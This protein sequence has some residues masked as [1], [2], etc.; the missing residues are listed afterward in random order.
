MSTKTGQYASVY[1]PVISSYARYWGNQRYQELIRK[2]NIVDTQMA[3]NTKI[4]VQ[5]KTKKKKRNGVK[6]IIKRPIPRTLQPRTKLIRVKMTDYQYFNCTTGALATKA[7]SGTD[8][9]NPL[10]ASSTQ[11]P[12]GYDQWKA[13]Y[14]TAYIVGTKVKMTLWNNSTTAV[15]CGITAMPKASASTALNSYEHYKELPHTHARMLSPDVDYGTVNMKVSTKKHLGIKDIS[16]ND[17]IRNNLF[18]DISPSEE[19]QL[20]CWLQ[21]LDQATTLNQVPCYIDIEYLV[22]LTN[23]IAPS[24]STA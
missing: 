21:P 18:S 23:P 1:S 3:G 10:G 6:G 11:Q 20:H 8:I 14:Q 12:L 17:T 2:K 5:T 9:V 4:Y 16:D 13:L 22:L 15:V 19:F 7:V 24:R